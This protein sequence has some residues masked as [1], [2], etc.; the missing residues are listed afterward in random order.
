MFW[1]IPE[2][3]AFSLE[4]SK[5]IWFCS[6]PEMYLLLQKMVFDVLKAEPFPEWLHQHVLVEEHS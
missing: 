1:G 3:S 6:F 5:Q 2:H 4:Y